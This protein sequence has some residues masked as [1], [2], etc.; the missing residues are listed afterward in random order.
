MTL[1]SVPVL[2]A[3]NHLNGSTAERRNKVAGALTAG[4]TSVTFVYASPLPQPGGRFEVDLEE[5]HV[6]DTDSPTKVANPVDRGAY[7]ST[8]AT[9]LDQAVARIAPRFPR[10]R[11]VSEMNAELRELSSPIHGL[12]RVRTAD[13]VYSSAVA[14]YDLAV[15][16]IIGHPLKVL[17][18]A[19][20]SSKYWPE[21]TSYRYDDNL[22]VADFA[23]T[24]AIF[25]FE[26]ASPG[27]TIR[28]FYRSA[29]SATLA[30]LT[31]D[32]ETVSGLPATA[33]DIL[34]LGASIRLMA[35]RPVRR[36]QTEA[37][38]DN[39]RAEEVSTNDVLNSP[40]ALR[41]LRE[42]AIAAERTRLHAAWPVRLRTA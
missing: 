11:I 1:L 26:G 41:Q 6:Y 34:A 19:S 33:I 5:F 23:S 30:A 42:S 8:A 20:G 32:V 37:Q 15:T 22:P 39:R 12:F 36:A 13:V 25:L 17:Y 35:G 28:V 29:F 21:I 38:G 7:G 16:D 14:G 9:H 40:S 3:E 10:H 24:K 4:V 18:K 2:T 31:D 27:S